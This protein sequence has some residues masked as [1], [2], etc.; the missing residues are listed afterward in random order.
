MIH[1]ISKPDPII[2][3]IIQ[4]TFPSYKGKKIKLSTDIPTRLDSYWD[5]GSKDTYVFYELKTSRIIPIAS[6]H[7]FFEKENP[8]NLESLPNGI[9]IVCH[10]I[11]CGKDM[12]ITIYVNNE[13]IA[14]MLPKAQNDIDKDERIVL[15]FTAALKNS[16]GGET[17]IRF[18]RANEKYGISRLNWIDAQ[19]RLVKKGLLRKNLSITPE[20]R[21]IDISEIRGY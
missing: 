8:R 18:K 9:L 15:A 19:N 1:Y 21:N 4:K 20:G 11:F 6:N 7:P 13:D 17:N 5:G 12:G 2:I 16:Y 3:K 10:S 14:P